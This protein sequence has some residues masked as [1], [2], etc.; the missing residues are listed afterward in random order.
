MH[1]NKPRP[2]RIALI[3]Q[4]ELAADPERNKADL[5]RVIDQLAGDADFVMPTE[6]ATTPY[7]GAVHDRSLEAWADT[8][9]GSFLARIK[10]IAAHR[11]CT[12]LLP[13][14][15]KSAD[16][17]FVNAVVV[18]G[19]DGRLVQGHV[20]GREPVSYFA[21]VH[22]PSARRDGK[23]IDEPFYFQRGDCFPVFETP[24]GRIGILTCY[25][26]RF[27]EA[28]RSLA[29]AGAELIFMPSC[30]PAWRPSA[31]ASTGDMFLAELRTRACENGVFVA[32]CNRVG[33]QTFQNT[34]THFIGG[35]C[36]I[37]P[38]GGLVDEAPATS[39][40]NLTVGIDLDDVRRVR[41]RLTLLEDRQV[42]AYD[43]QARR[44]SPNPRQD[45]A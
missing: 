20:R 32:A 26:R 13:I 9:D 35:S 25:D 6:L 41:R 14:Y 43:L 21:K 24:L 17:M 18:V 39:A 27:P 19:P 16:G 7:F 12:V 2:V 30:V 8:L 33:D 29:L 37:D 40:A 1:E 15:L 42:D 4:A 5:C 11:R 10:D 45:H 3:Q 44:R 31:K 34:V 28:W 36:V 23:G 38:A 22:L